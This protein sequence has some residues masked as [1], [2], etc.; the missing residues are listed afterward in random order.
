MKNLCNQK[1]EDFEITDQ[2]KSASKSIQYISNL[3]KIK[4]QI[5]LIFF[6][7]ISYLMASFI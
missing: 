2:L 1:I 4:D 7:L 5:K 3:V 6:F